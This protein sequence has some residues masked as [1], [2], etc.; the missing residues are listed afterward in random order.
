M[1]RIDADYKKTPGIAFV[2]E[3]LLNPRLSVFY[4]SFQ[5]CKT[6]S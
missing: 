3:N 4:F 2:C 1:K 6:C 5:I